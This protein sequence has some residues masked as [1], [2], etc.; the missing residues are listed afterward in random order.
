MHYLLL[1]TGL[2]LTWAA[3]TGTFSLPNLLLGFGLGYA[4][5]WL[6]RSVVGPSSYFSKV[7]KA[8]GFAVF[9]LWELILSNLRVAAD[10]LTPRHHMQPRV[11]AIPLEA[12]TNAEITLLANFISLTPGSLSLDVASDCRV[13]YVHVMYA[14]D[15][16]LVRREIEQGLERRLLDV[17][18]GANDEMNVGA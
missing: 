13:L 14:A 10:V 8:L 4:V 1:N 12:R 6:V 17:M 5:L 9:F 15:A 7:P 3:L 16:E 2:A 11:L 18:R